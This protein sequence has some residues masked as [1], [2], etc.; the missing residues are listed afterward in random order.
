M[1]KVRRRTSSVVVCVVLTEQVEYS[2][3]AESRATLE[4]VCMRLPEER[5]LSSPSDA[6]WVGCEEKEFNCMNGQCISAADVCDKSYECANGNDE[7]WW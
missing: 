3:E 7:T 4:A 2:C 5:C 6:A 1:G